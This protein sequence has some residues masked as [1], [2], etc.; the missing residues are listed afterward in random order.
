MWG[1]IIDCDGAIRH[2]IICDNRGSAGSGIITSDG[3][4]EGNVIARNRAGAGGGLYSCDGTIQNNLIYN[5]FGRVGGGGLHDCNGVVRNNTIYGNT[6]EGDGGGIDFCKGTIVNN[7]VWANEAPDDPQIADSVSPSYCCIQDWDGDGNSNLTDDPR[8]GD[9]DNLNFYLLND[10]PC[11]DSGRFVDDLG[12]D[13][14]GDPRPIN[15]TLT[16]RGDGSDIDVGADEYY[17]TFN[18]SSDVYSDLRINYFDLFLFS[19]GWYIKTDF[20]DIRD[21][22]LDQRV[23]ILDLF[24]LLR[25]WGDYTAP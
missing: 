16:H 25:D 7:I 2:N 19:T 5:N 13:F 12:E 21:I 24:L 10:S 20:P 15:A 17:I 9:P 3:L 18:L 11:I 14:W 1:G 22:D 4:I 6:S 8:L 23:D